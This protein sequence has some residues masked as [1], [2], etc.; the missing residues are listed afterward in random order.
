M[1]PEIDSRGQW[2]SAS[3]AQADFLCPGRHRAQLGI[4]EP[5]PTEDAESGTRIHAWLENC[6]NSTLGPQLSPDEQDVADKCIQIARE[7]VPKL[8]NGITPEDGVVVS[9]REERLWLEFDGLKHSGKPD[10][11]HIYGQ[12]AICIDWKCGRNEVAES[13]RNLQLRD[14]AVLVAVNYGVS[15][16]HVAIIQ[17]WVTMT[18]EV[19]TY[20]LEDL[21]AAKAALIERVKASNAPDAKRV[22]GEEQCKYCRAK[23]VCKEFMDASLPVQPTTTAAASI[24]DAIQGLDSLRLGQF[25]SLVRLAEQTATSEVRRRLNEGV[26][27]D[28]WT[29]NPGGE[30][31]KIV[32]A[33]TVFARALKAGVTQETFVKSCVSVTK[34]KLKDALKAATGSKG[35]ALDAELDALLA[36]ATETKTSEPILTKV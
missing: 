18:P 14:L 32:D 1:Q 10:V 36:G 33:Q 29:L 8:L 22:P 9:H 5:P 20:E 19:C 12:E 31:E 15:K 28:G 30:T 24:P 3:A 16:V 23:G 34:G 2:T 17:P 35:K 4:P 26:G 27:V 21:L 7:L 6:G 13:P 11:V 25:L